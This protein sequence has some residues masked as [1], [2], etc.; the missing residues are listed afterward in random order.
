M[1]ISIDLGLRENLQPEYESD[2]ANRMGAEHMEFIT[3]WVEDR[4]REH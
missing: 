2:F 4:A 3:D 1:E